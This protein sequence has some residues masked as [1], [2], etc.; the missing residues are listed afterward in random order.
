LS[1]YLGERK[2]CWNEWEETDR[3]KENRE[4]K[5]KGEMG[6]RERENTTKLSRPT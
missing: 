6:E 3:K 4:R 1:S 2:G 5:K